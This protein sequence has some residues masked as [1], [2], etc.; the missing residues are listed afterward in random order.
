MRRRFRVGLINQLDCEVDMSFKSSMKEP[1]PKYWKATTNE[2]GGSYTKTRY[3]GVV[4]TD[5]LSAVNA[6]MRENPDAIIVSIS[7]EGPVNVLAI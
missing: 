6:I 1:I 3:V 5:V 2:P 7:H 4:A